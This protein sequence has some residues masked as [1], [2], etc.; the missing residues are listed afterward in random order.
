VIIRSAP[1]KEALSVRVGQRVLIVGWGPRSAKGE[2]VEI[3]AKR[4]GCITS[5]V[6]VSGGG[7]VQRFAPWTIQPKQLVAEKFTV[8]LRVNG[9]VRAVDN[10]PAN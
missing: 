2:T 6:K 1:K 3:C 9:R 10:V 8:R 5:P 7:N 4:G